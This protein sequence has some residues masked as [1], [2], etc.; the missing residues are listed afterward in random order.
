MSLV[1]LVLLVL[2]AIVFWETF[3]SHSRTI[4]ELDEQ[5]QVL[6]QERELVIGF[7]HHMVEALGG[8]ADRTVLWDRI[9]HA[10]IQATGALSAA[11]FE[12]RKGRQLRGVAVEG[13]FPPHRHLPESSR[14]KLTT[15]AKYLEQILKAETFEVGEGIVGSVAQTKKGEL[16]ADATQDER[17]NQHDDPALLVRSIIVCPILFQ[18]ELLGV[19][20]VVN[21]AD[22]LAFNKTDFSLVENLAEQA[23]LA[24]HNA[25]TMHIQI[26][27]NR[28]DLELELASNIQGLLLPKEFP[29]ND[30]LDAHAT[31]IPAQKVGGDLYDIFM[32]DEHRLGVAIA[33][34]SGKGVPGSL[35]MAICQ[36]NLR[37]F[38]RRHDSPARVLSAINREMMNAGMRRDKFVTMVYGI[39]NTRK[40]ELVL[41]RAGHELPLILQRVGP[42]RKAEVVPVRTEGIALGMVPP[43]M[44]D[45]VVEDKVL[46]FG[47]GEAL[48]LYTDGVTETTNS[49]S[50]EFSFA[51]MADAVRVLK[52][53]PAREV[54]AGILEAVTRFSNKEY[55]EDDLTL[56]TVVRT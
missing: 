9:V 20:A 55:Y 8:G 24:I 14:M 12:L 4:A 37:H 17:I 13:L 47:T 54:N 21:P 36:T 46:S 30:Q 15:R 29:G 31:Y 44:F 11:A 48:V 26:E 45:E 3:K 51:R 23:G 42:H 27:K 35:L 16:V 18:E 22:G 19:L 1:L 6:E 5:N 28:L 32:L 39:I 34:V 41:S 49:E 25:D 2:L 10:S 7:M 50:T 38:A 40:N 52:D 56:L 53:R 43:E 33:D